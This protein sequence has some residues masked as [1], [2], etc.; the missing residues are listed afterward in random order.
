MDIFKTMCFID[1]DDG[2]SLV[3]TIW[4]KGDWWLVATWLQHPDTG[5]RIP[6]RIVRPTV[7]GPKL[8]EAPAGKNYRFALSNAIPMSAL[9]GVSQDEFLIE[10][11]SM[12]LEH[13]QKR[14][15]NP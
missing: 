7:I 14:G 8:L 12:A 13:T 5:H 4:Y 11:H 3:D 1:D 6:E 2:P 10:T 9:G 15:S